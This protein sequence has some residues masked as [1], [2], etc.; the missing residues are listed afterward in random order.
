MKNI[1]FYA[2]EGAGKSTQAKML[3]AKLGVPC[4]ISGDLVRWG[5][6]DRK[7]TRLNSSH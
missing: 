6:E 2:P 1:I 3:A 7:S 5:A 4:L